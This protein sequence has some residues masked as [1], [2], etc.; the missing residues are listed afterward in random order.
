VAVRTNGKAVRETLAL[1]GHDLTGCTVNVDRLIRIAS[2]V[3]DRVVTCASSAGFPLTSTQQQDL[4]TLL[5]AQLFANPRGIR[6]SETTG[7]ASA[8]Y[9]VDSAKTAYMDMA[10]M[11][12]TSG[13]L[14][15]VLSGNKTV[16]I[17]WLGKTL[18]EQ[19]DYEDRN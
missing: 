4:E 1:G 15:K 3:V 9:N 16:G 2:S 12:D 17:A 8:S 11:M 10:K 19:T 18:T 13:C 6:T 5:A 14:G 7:R